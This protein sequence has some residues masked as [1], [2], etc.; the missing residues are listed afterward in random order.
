M[1]NLMEKQQRYLSLRRV[2]NLFYILKGERFIPTTHFLKVILFLLGFISVHHSS[3]SQDSTQYEIVQ[4][5]NTQSL[6]IDR[7]QNIYLVSDK[8]DIHKQGDKKHIYSS[9]KRK[10]I[11]HLEAWNSL[12]L[13]LF[14]RAYQEYTL[15]DRY[16]TEI[17]IVAFNPD[18]LGFVSYAT[19]ALDGNIWAIDNTDF[20]LKKVDIRNN[21]TLVTTNLNFVL[22]H[23]ENEV[24]FMKASNNFLYVCTAS[25]GILVFDNMGNYKKKLP[26][27][28]I[29]FLGFKDQKLYFANNNELTFFN[30]ITLEKKVELLPYTVSKALIVD[31]KLYL[32]KK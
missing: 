17:S 2:C 29:S 3:F 4:L 27:N 30:L 28:A 12:K 11:T 25:S 15:L 22:E 32:I 7:Y 20:S 23:T 5:E 18:E 10:D 24:L 31:Q 26:F 16:L 8:Q 13:F 1:Q 9:R 14:N 19:L 6:S 21:K